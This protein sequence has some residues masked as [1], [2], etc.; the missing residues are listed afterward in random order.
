[1]LNMAKTRLEITKMIMWMVVGLNQELNENY[2]AFIYMG[3][4]LFTKT[5][6]ELAWNQ[7]P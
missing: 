4:T 3:N 6:W 1:M 2:F 7:T 5:W